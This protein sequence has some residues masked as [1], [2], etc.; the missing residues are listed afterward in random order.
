MV[1]TVTRGTDTSGFSGVRRSC[2]KGSKKYGFMAMG[3]DTLSFAS[4]CT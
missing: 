1:N 2:G 3:Y 4:F